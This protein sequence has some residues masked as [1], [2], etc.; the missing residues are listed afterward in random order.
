M[1]NQH[2]RHAQKSRCLRKGEAAYRPQPRRKQEGRSQQKPHPQGFF[3]PDKALQNALG[4]HAQR[5]RQKRQ[6]HPGKPCLAGKGA[7]KPVQRPCQQT[8]NVDMHICGRFAAIAQKG[9]Q[10][11]GIIVDAV[12]HFG[13]Q[14][15]KGEQD[16]RHHQGVQPAQP[17]HKRRTLHFRMNSFA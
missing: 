13:E 3:V 7:A 12:S 8:M 9:A 11:A 10:D 2:S 15:R 5:Q 1:A 14:Q 6:L 4:N 16:S 17:A